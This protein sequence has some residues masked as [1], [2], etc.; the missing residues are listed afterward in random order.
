MNSLIIWRS[1]TGLFAGSLILVQ[2]YEFIVFI[3]CSVI[4]DVIPADK[5]NVYLARL[6]GCLSVSFIVGPAIGG[7]LGQISYQFPMFVMDK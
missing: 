3:T 6:E 7:V 5:R 4:A 1:F 2:A